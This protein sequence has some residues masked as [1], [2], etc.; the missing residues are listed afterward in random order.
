MEALKSLKNKIK[1]QLSQGFFWTL[2][3]FILVLLVSWFY[4][5]PPSGNTEEERT[6]SFL[7]NNFQTLISDLVANK[8]PEV[9]KITF[10]KI[11]TKKTSDLHEIK[12]FFSYSLWMEGS[13]GGE[14]LIDGEAL[15][16]NSDDEGELWIV[17]DFQVT[18]SFMDFS[19][20]L[21]IKAKLSEQL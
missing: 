14:L 17:Q 4:L 8:H 1:K 9:N 2:L 10:H 21:I 18:N 19:E 11:W 16:K 7:Q 13:P 6:H 15:L 12:I 5:S 3:G 20:P